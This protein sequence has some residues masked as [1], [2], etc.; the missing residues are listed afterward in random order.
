MALVGIAGEL[1]GWVEWGM[2]Y[3]YVLLFLIYFFWMNHS[4]NTKRFLRKEIICGEKLVYCFSRFY[5]SLWDNVFGKQISST[6]R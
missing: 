5:G 2:F 6:L 1:L 4:W 3:A